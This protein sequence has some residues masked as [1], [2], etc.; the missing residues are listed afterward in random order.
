MNFKNYLKELKRRNVVKSG[1]AYLVIAWLLIQVLYTLLPTFNAA[2]FLKPTVIILIIGFPIWIIFSWIFELTPEGIKKTPNIVIN[3]I[4][5]LALVDNR[6]SIAVL[7]FYNLTGNP[8][9]DYLIDGMHE[10]LNFH[11]GK[12]SALRVISTRSTLRYKNNNQLS[13]Q[14]IAKD[15][16]VIAIIEGSVLNSGDSIHIQLKLIEAFPKEHQLWSGEYYQDFGQVLT[17]ENQIIQD[18][19]M[20]MKVN[21]KPEEASE[22]AKKP[23]IDP[24]AYKAYMQGVFYWNKLTSESLNTALKYFEI[25]RDIDSKYA[26]AYAGI[27]NVWVG[28]AQLGLASYVEALPKIEEAIEKA[29]TLDSTSAEIYETKAWLSWDRWNFEET[30]VAYRKAIQL[31]PNFS[32]A[33]AYFSHYLISLNKPDEAMQHMEIA[34]KL[35]PFNSLYKAIYGMNLN[36]TRQYDK[37]IDIFESTLKTSPNDLLVL[38]NLRTSYHLKGM[39]AKALEVWK[40]Y[41]NAKNDKEAVDVLAKGEAEG[42]YQKALEELVELLIDRSDSTFVTPWQI[43]TIYTRAGQKDKALIWLEKAFAYHDANMPYIGVDPIFDIL[44]DDP[45]FSNL[46]KKMKL[47][48]EN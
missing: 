25:A 5:D 20:K 21:L 16:D 32:R 41:Y 43:A 7:P 45:R 48:V 30:I 34:L 31:N 47:P 15:L 37:A 10:T 17:M 40:A 2:Q 12:I 29:L 11:L 42:G 1:L 18:I 13:L 26:L 23:Q 8:D 22:L 3:K 14:E 4:T 19:T 44:K 36:F 38:S 24:E 9:Q 39:F 27:A 35:D 6:K 28:K 46:L 33:R